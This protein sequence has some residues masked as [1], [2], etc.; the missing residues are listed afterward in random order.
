M[1]NVVDL[2]RLK[3][4][5]AQDPFAANI[6]ERVQFP[7]P[8][9]KDF[10]SSPPLV[11]TD[12]GLS[13]LRNRETPRIKD[14]MDYLGSQ[15]KRED[16]QA[17]K[18]SKILAAVAGGAEGWSKGPTAGVNTFKGLT[19]M[20]FIEAQEDWQRKGGRLKE[21]SDLEYRGLNDEQKLA[22]QMEDYRLKNAEN[23]RQWIELESGLGLKKAQVD[24]IVNQIKNR[25]LTVEDNEQTGE[26]EVVDKLTGIR[27]S[28]GKFAESTKD[29]DTRTRNLFSYQSGVTEGRQSRLQEDSQ[30]AALNLESIRTLNDSELAKF[31]S[32]L[33]RED[34][35]L[36]RQLEGMTPAAQK[37][38]LEL[39]F[40]QV[41]LD[42]PNLDRTKD[43]GKFMTEV[44]KRLKGI[45]ERTDKD[46]GTNIDDDPLGLFDETR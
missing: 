15:P 21:L 39:A 14:Y 43:P 46:I 18:V 16:Y 45:R 44:R 7:S 1:S 3:R 30:L 38:T 34:E 32:T 8:L 19:E 10:P 13:G 42:L 2:L 4:L 20:P 27:T 28:L 26:K 41:S 33:G 25:G 29:K 12:T 9:I 40:Q 37:T 35:T 23:T 24:N 17:G 11:P 6:K 36:K 31:R 22:I 5:A